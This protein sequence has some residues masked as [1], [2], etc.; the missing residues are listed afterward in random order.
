MDMIVDIDFSEKDEPAIAIKMRWDALPF[1][2]KVG[3]RGPLC[4]LVLIAET[5]CQKLPTYFATW[6]MNALQY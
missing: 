2:P 4:G 1:W 5:G 3:L 6:Q